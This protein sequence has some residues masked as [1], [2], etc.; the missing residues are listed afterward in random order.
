MNDDDFK[1]HP[2]YTYDIGTSIPLE[3]TPYW[4][5]TELDGDWG[6]DEVRGRYIFRFESD[7][8]KMWFILRWS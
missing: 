5:E 4:L 6:L 8:D 7:R 1:V 3:I 2:V